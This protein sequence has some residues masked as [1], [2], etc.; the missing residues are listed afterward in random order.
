VVELTVDTAV[1]HHRWRHPAHFIRVRPDL[2]TDDLTPLPG[3]G[4]GGPSRTAA[5]G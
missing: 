5:A 2:R 3:S 1:E 4:S